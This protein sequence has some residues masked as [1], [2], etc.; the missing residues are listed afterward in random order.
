MKMNYRFALPLPSPRRLAC[1]LPLMFA[2]AAAHAT[3][4]WVDTHTKAFLTG[5]SLCISTSAQAALQS[6]YRTS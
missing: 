5:P 2:A 4:D 6:R 3:T 1:A